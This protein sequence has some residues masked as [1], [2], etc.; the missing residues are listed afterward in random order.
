MTMN[1]RSRLI[2]VAREMN[3]SGLNQ[4][5]SGNLSGR[6]GDGML[7][8]PSGMA[9]EELSPEDIV[10]VGPVAAAQPAFD[11]MRE[12]YSTPTR[13]TVQRSLACG[14][15]YPPSTTW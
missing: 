8:T 5:T 15:P 12:R 7:I 3:R 9:Y 6:S 14:A 13:C 2:E 1:L 10:Y 11:G 4:G